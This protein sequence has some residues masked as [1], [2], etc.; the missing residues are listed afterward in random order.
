MFYRTELG[1]WLALFLAFVVLVREWEDLVLEPL[2][3][4]IP[5]A[6]RLT[7]FP[8]PAWLVGSW[9]PFFKI[10]IYLGIFGTIWTAV[11]ELFADRLSTCHQEIIFQRALKKLLVELQNLEQ[12]EGSEQEIKAYYVQFVKRIVET[13]SRTFSLN[14]AKMR[15]D[16]VLMTLEENQLKFLLCN[17]FAEDEGC[18]QRDLAIS[19]PEHESDYSSSGPAGLSYKKDRTVYL[20]EKAK[21]RADPKEVWTMEFEPTATDIEYD[22]TDPR[23]CWRSCDVERHEDFCTV[24]SVPIKGF[25]VLNFSTKARDKFITRDFFMAE[26]FAGILGHATAIYNK[27]KA[28]IST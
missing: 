19:V 23:T 4:P 8:P 17:K 2:V 26:F 14:S 11:I 16:V 9:D 7:G 3:R 13:A 10:L 5:V 20:P 12:L 21:F 18:F 6:L 28:P 15:V 22:A 1:R 24:I 27:K 25:G